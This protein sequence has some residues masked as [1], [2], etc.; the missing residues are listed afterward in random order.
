M[1]GHGTDALVGK[2]VYYIVAIIFFLF[3][4]ITTPDPQS[5]VSPLYGT[6]TPA[7]EALDLK[8]SRIRLRMR[9]ISTDTPGI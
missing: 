3:T 1:R 9:L 7:R 8:I 6:H 5:T 4:A 2:V